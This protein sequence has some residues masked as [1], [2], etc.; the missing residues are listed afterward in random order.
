MSPLVLLHGFT[1][2][3]A[4]FDRLC[5]AFAS[6][7]RARGSD[8]GETRRGGDEETRRASAP[9]DGLRVRN[10]DAASSSPSLLVSPKIPTARAPLSGDA[11]SPEPSAIIRPL[12][13][14]HGPDPVR[15]ASWDAEI[16]RLVALLRRELDA[17]AHL[18]GY[19]LG[20]RVG[21]GLLAR[22][23][24]LFAR[25]TL[26]GAHPG[27]IEE[28]EREARR[29]ADARWIALLEREGLDAFIAEWEALPLWATQPPAMIEAQ[30]A[31]RRSHRAEG[32]AHALEALGLGAMPPVDPAAIT[33]PLTL[34]AGQHDAKHRALAEAFAPRLGARVHVVPNAG[35]NVLAEAPDALVEILR[36]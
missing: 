7:A 17:P 18:V 22:A 13:A 19:S 27:L 34:V 11:T 20:G 4:A 30:R 25:A 28:S 31:I 9:E 33:T 15:V 2:S 35:H 6:P 8:C 36:C 3:P 26:I 16:D 10:A 21:Y 24:E 29:A 23:P 14:G 5:S 12:L 1:G 32:L